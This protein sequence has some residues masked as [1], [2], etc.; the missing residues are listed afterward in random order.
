[1]RL[2][3]LCAFVLLVIPA[4]L[5]AQRVSEPT[6]DLFGGFSFEHPTATNSVDLYGFDASVSERPYRSVPW[7]GGT[8]EASGAYSNQTTTIINV[9]VS[10]S[11]SQYTFMGGPMIALPSGHVR[12]FARALFGEVIE[13]TSVSNSSTTTSLQNFGLAAGGGIDL[14]I[15]SRWAVRGQADW[16]YIRETSTSASKYIRASAGIVFRF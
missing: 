3:L 12:P 8:I 6:W 5:P 10:T 4:S 2:P 7:V 16:L 13:D 9:P 14:S 15:N 1:V 11:L